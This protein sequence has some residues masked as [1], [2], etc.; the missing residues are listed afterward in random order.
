MASKLEEDGSI[1]STSELNSISCSDNNLASPS[2]ETL[3]AER[4]NSQYGSYDI[5]CANLS[6][7]TSDEETQSEELAPV[8][9][10]T[11]KSNCQRESSC[12]SRSLDSPCQWPPRH[13][14][15]P[16]LCERNRSPYFPKLE[17]V[18]VEYTRGDIF[19]TQRNGRLSSS[20]ADIM[21]LE[22]PTHKSRPIT[23]AER[24][25]TFDRMEL[26]KPQAFY[27]EPDLSE[28]C[29][30][31]NPSPTIDMHSQSHSE[32]IRVVGKS[33]AFSSRL[34]ARNRPSTNGSPYLLLCG[35]DCHENDQNPL[36]EPAILDDDGPISHDTEETETGVGK[37]GDR[38]EH[39]DVKHEIRLGLFKDV[40]L[41]QEHFPVDGGVH[42]LGDGRE[43]E[44]GENGNTETQ[45]HLS[46]LL[47][48]QLPKEGK[49]LGMD[50][51][52]TFD[53]LIKSCVDK[54]VDRPREGRVS[55]HQG[56]ESDEDLVTC[57]QH[58]GGDDDSSDRSSVSPGLMAQYEAMLLGAEPSSDIE[59]TINH[60]QAMA[61]ETDK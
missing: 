59:E 39:M 47:L 36:L 54:L 55:S 9:G 11:P 10:H 23:P 24:S 13:K 6:Y 22:M 8:G 31:I 25:M 27:S 34:P 35:G 50:C 40:P 61:A 41:Y 45:K 43:E 1:S 38:H 37:T 56:K 53:P 49:T 12:R 42:S 19:L 26:S 46:E 20:L 32:D 51:I 44:E 48:A 33:I 29:G 28:A 17:G 2:L 60:L 16:S 21:D 3:N 14:I 58:S 15:R 4:M 5:I 52:V 57:D 7:E 30:R 18:K